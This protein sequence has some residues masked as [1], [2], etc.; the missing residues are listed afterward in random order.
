MITEIGIVRGAAL[1]YLVIAIFIFWLIY[2]N[3]G[4]PDALKNV[5]VIV[6]TL[7]P[8]FILTFTYLVPQKTVKTFSY[9]LIF[10]SQSKQVIFGSHWNQYAR[11]YSGV[12]TNLTKDKFVFE[13]WMELMGK[14]G[15]DLIEKGIVSDLTTYMSYSWD[16]QPLSYKTP[17][18]LVQTRQMSNQKSEIIKIEDI[19]KKFSYNPLIQLPEVIV[20]SQVSLPPGSILSTKDSDK[21]TTN[22]SRIITIQNKTAITKIEVSPSY[23]GVAQQGV[24]GVV[25]PDPSNMNRYA[26]VNFT[27]TLSIEPRRFAQYS[28]EMKK[29]REWEENISNLLGKMDWENI[30]MEIEKDYILKASKTILQNNP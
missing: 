15:L 23:G 10:D 11:A 9:S 14:N 6:G 25:S 8:V 18:G 30:Q 19:L 1:L 3:A 20:G 4:A 22:D 17:N 24:I 21:T 5:G 2:R 13:N 26:V 7:I 29:Y 12:Q 16:G 27:V 28:P